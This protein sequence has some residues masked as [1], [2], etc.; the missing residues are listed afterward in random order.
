MRP[1]APP[2]CALLVVPLA[3]AG[4]WPQFLG[5]TRNGVA[6]DAD[7]RGDWPAGGPPRVWEREVGHGFSGPAVAGGK[8][9]L[10]HRLGDEEAVECLEAATGKP[11]WKS[12]A[13]TDY[14]DDF[15]FDDGPR[16]TPVVAGGHV[17]TF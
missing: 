5:P 9:V 14:V 6:A 7:V 11:L 1:A 13:P 4:D 15:G 3:V 16:A 17:Y 12:A 8:L 2:L 10:F